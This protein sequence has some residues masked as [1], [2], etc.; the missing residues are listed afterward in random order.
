MSFRNLKYPRKRV[1][2]Q[3]TGVPRTK[4]Q[5]RDEVNVNTILRKY[6][7]QGILPP[8]KGPG[9]YGDFS[10]IEDYQGAINTV[11]SAQAAF[12]DQ[13][14]AL[15][16]KFDNDPGK[17]LEFVQ[18]PANRKELVALGLATE[19]IDPVLKEQHDIREMRKKKSESPSLKETPKS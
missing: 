12:M 8:M 11:M 1:G 7:K 16:Q 17:F 19:S 3:T 15:R 4:Q 13:P 10:N 5:F 18:N 9:S 2:F 6:L 14:S